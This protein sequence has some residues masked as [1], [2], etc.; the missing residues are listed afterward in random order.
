[1]HKQENKSETPTMGGIAIFASILISI[2]LWVELSAEVFI[3]LLGAFAF[4]ALGA[5]DDIK[6]LRRKG[7]DGL[8]GKKKLVVQ[9]LISN[10][11]LQSNYA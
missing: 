2:L 5:F 4:L 11:C 10:R 9:L 6:K 7:K 8:S 3:G 1:M